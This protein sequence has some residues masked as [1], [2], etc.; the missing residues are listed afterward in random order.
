MG[1]E[2]KGCP[3]RNICPE[4]RNGGCP[5][6]TETEEWEPIE[7]FIETT[8]GFLCLDWNVGVNPY[9]LP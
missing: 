2:T 9:R 7:G 5:G 8:D 1:E 3:Y 4:A 6:D